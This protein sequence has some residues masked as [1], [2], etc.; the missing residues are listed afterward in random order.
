M[1]LW[2]SSILRV[3]PGLTWSILKHRACKAALSINRFT[4]EIFDTFND[5]NNIDVFVNVIDGYWQ[6]T[7]E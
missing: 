6:P 2:V 5:E 1:C 3:K 4:P 7:E